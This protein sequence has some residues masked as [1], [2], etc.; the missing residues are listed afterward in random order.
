MRDATLATA[1]ALQADHRMARTV[2]FRT[3][4]GVLSAA[5]QGD[6]AITLDFPAASIAEAPIPDGLA[7]ALG[8]TPDAAYSTGALTRLRYR[9]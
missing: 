9:I 7:A 1:H 6:G 8:N 2:R 4:S 5:M 3:R